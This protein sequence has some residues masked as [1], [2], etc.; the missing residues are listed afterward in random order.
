MM[1]AGGDALFGAEVVSADEIVADAA[2]AMAAE[3]QRAFIGGWQALLGGLAE[4]AQI[5]ERAANEIEVYI[6]SRPVF[7][8]FFDGQTGV[9]ADY[10]GGLHEVVDLG[11]RVRVGHERESGL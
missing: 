8:A 10:F 1:P 9:G 4:V 11:A 6:E 7:A 5:D 2:H 3:K